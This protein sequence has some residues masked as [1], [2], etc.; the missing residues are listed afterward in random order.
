MEEQASLCCPADSAGRASA[1]ACAGPPG[2]GAA[3]APLGLSLGQARPS[4][5]RA[6]TAGPGEA[7]AAGPKAAAATSR[8]CQATRRGRKGGAALPARPV[9]AFPSRPPPPRWRRPCRCRWSSG[10]R[11]GGGAWGPQRGPGTRAEGGAALG[12]AA[13]GLTRSGCCARPAGPPRAE[14]GPGVPSHGAS[15]PRAGPEAAVAPGSQ[16]GVSGTARAVSRSAAV[17]PGPLRCCPGSGAGA[18]A[19]PALPASHLLGVSGA[20]G[21]PPAPLL[22]CFLIIKIIHKTLPLVFRLLFP[23]RYKRVWCDVR[24]HTL[25]LCFA[26]RLLQVS[27]KEPG[28]RFVALWFPGLRGSGI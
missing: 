7:A 6:G 2:P 11:G 4:R 14:L 10:E 13:A 19:C 17:R 23:Y 9:R 28:S 26:S 12:E 16:P 24:D 20:P 1:G 27:V 22:A 21:P 25:S 18:A 3:E 5:G 15:A 8:R